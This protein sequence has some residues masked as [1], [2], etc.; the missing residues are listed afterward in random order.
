MTWNPSHGER[1][2][3]ERKSREMVE[4][5]LRDLG[6]STRGFKEEVEA[7]LHRPL[8]KPRQS[9]SDEKTSEPER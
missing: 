7:L 3:I 4:Q 5:W 2:R 9:G 1:R 6:P 8:A